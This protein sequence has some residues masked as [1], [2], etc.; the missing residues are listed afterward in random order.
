L[1]AGSIGDFYYA[2][3]FYGNGT[4][5]EVRGTWRDQGFG[6]LEDLGS[7]VLDL[8]ADLFQCGGQ[9]FQAWSLEHHEAATFDHGM[10]AS[11]DGRIVLEVSYLSWKNTF[12]MD[13]FGSRGS[14]HVQGLQKWGP[15]TLIL[16][17]RVLPSG[18]PIEVREDA[19]G[20]IDP[21][22][23]RDL[24]HFEMLCTAPERGTS[25]D[26]DLW[27]TRSLMEAAST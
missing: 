19:P 11:A 2:R 15:C 6:V 16:R 27:I 3:L 7:H 26:N 12:S 4:V 13:I 23:E 17:Q 24:E 10:L 21:T 25:V 9:P 20:G 14:L 5:A 1:R 22:W 18:V 8:A